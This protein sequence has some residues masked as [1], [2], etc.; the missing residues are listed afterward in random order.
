M[1]NRKTNHRNEPCGK[2]GAARE[3]LEFQDNQGGSHLKTLRK[4]AAVKELE[5][6]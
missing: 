6:T 4:A 5:R 1:I 2:T 3:N